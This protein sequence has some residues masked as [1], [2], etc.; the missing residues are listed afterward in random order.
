MLIVVPFHNLELGDS[1]DPPLGVYIESKFPVNCKPIELL[2]FLPPVRNSPN[3]V[4]VV[5]YRLL[6]PHRTGH[7]I[8][9][10]FDVP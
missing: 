1:D 9:N 8:F 3:G 6:Y 2:M 4:P 7:Q 5:V 10:P